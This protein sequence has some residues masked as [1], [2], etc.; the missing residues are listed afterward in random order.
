[1]TGSE[2]DEMVAA[3]CEKARCG[4]SMSAPASSAVRAFFHVPPAIVFSCMINRAHRE[5]SI[6]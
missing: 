6:A 5:C 4:M 1:M 3:H 2:V